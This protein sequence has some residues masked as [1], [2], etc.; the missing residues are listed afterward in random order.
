MAQKDQ[1]VEKTGPSRIAPKYVAQ[2]TLQY[3]TFL[4]RTMVEALQNAFNLYADPTLL[5]TKI[6]VDYSS[7]R[8]DYPAIVVKFYEQ[9]I[10]NIG[11]GHKEWG[12]VEDELRLFG[13]GK[14]TKGSGVIGELPTVQD[15]F[16]G[17]TEVKGSG[18]PQ[19]TFVLK[20]IDAH[21]ILVNK[22]ASQSGEENL[23]FRGSVDLFTKFIEYHHSM[24]QGDVALEVY[25]LSS[26]DRDKIADAILEIVQMGTVGPEGVSFQERIYDTIGLSPYSDWHFIAVNTD[27]VS[28]FGEREEMPPWGP[29]DQLLYRCEYRVPILGE[30]YSVTPQLGAGTLD[31]V[32]EVDVYPWNTVGISDE[33]DGAFGEIAPEDFPGGVIPTDDY[34]HIVNH[35]KKEPYRVR[36]QLGSLGLGASLV[37]VKL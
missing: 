34:Y 6:A 3:K 23:S 22:P 31:L 10:Q 30:F 8:A 19:G 5:K 24:Y 32:R 16:P 12:P 2:Q 21:S 14:L 36:T 9:T 25:G 26:V 13:K 20:I 29:E 4:K 17:E 11:V 18:L 35:P 37:P 33:P 7:D 27:L 28:G 1:L 15:L